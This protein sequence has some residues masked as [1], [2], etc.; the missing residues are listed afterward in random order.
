MNPA[1]LKFGRSFTAIVGGI[2]NQST[3][4][5]P[6]VLGGDSNSVVNAEGGVVAGGHN[7]LLSS[8]SAD[9]SSIGP[10]IFGP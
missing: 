7:R 8:P 10:Q 9:S 6:V 1:C 5:G 4:L 3:P 2:G